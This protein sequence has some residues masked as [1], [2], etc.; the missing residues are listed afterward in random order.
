MEIRDGFNSL[1]IILDII[2]FVRTVQVIVIQSKAHKH[3][4]NAQLLGSSK[5]EYCHRHVPE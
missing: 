5:W 3:D 4:L 2:F 1:V